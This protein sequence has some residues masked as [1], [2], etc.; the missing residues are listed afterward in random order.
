MAIYRSGGCEVS[1]GDF[2]YLIEDEPNPE[3]VQQL[4]AGLVAFNDRRAE[5]ENRIPLGVFVRRGDEILGGVDGYT[6][7]QWLYVSH[8]WVRDDVRGVGVGSHL[9]STIEAQA[10]DRECSRAWLDTFSFQAPGFYESI[11]YQRFGEL[12]DFPPGSLRHFLWKPL[13]DPTF[14]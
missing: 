13:T 12:P 3:H 1:S 7:W 14:D 6:H 2:D 11:G 5:R 10:R 4:I 9:M 8:L